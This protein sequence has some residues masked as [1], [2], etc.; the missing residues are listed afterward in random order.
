M[1]SG[2]ETVGDLDSC[3]QA[4]HGMKKVGWVTYLGS[5]LLSRLLEKF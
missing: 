1:Q 5:D 4:L 3:T 2:C